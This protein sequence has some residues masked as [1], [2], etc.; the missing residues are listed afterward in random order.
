MGPQPA[1]RVLA[2]R[3]LVQLEDEACDDA[4]LSEMVLGYYA[5]GA[6]CE[7]TLH[8]NRASYAR[9]KLLPRML[10]DVSLIDMRVE[11]FGTLYD[12]RAWS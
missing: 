4:N 6:D 7:T 3:S 1:E 12:T 2:I 8:D 10:R 9:F 5:S 11:L